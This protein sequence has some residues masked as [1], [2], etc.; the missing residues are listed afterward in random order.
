MPESN[1]PAPGSAALLAAP[2]RTL[3]FAGL[4][5]LLAA[6]AWWGLH[7]VARYTGAPLFALALQPAPIWA[8]A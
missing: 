1:V 5:S 6:S 3:F 2:H 8:H 4:L 7:I